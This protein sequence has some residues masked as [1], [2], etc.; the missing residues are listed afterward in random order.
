[1]DDRGLHIGGCGGGRD[2]KG[3]SGEQETAEHG[4]YLSC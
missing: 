4:R 1:M 2:R 3:G